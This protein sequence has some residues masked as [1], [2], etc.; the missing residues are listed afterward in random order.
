MIRHVQDESR[1]STAHVP[2]AVTESLGL[3][4]VSAGTKSKASEHA[5]DDDAATLDALSLRH[6]N[7][8]LRSEV[9]SLKEHVCVLTAECNEYER[10]IANLRQ[11]N[12]GAHLEA[13]ARNRALVDMIKQL[14][15]QVQ[16]MRQRENALMHE[17]QGFRKQLLSAQQHTVCLESCKGMSERD[18]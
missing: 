2:I 18:D 10:R 16:D 14:D 5:D 15:Q 4:S 9:L 11:E 1:G 8:R 12:H 3:T 7:M 13:V 17:N 6:I